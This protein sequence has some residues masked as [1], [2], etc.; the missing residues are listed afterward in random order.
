MAETLAGN[1][2]E[3]EIVARYRASAP[4][5]VDGLARELGIIVLYEDLGPNVAGMITVDDTDGPDRYIIRVHE[6]DPKRRRRFTLAHEVGH[7][8]LHR[9]LMDG[10]I[11]DNTMY[12]S[13]LGEWYER[14]ANRFAA[15]LLLP[16]HLVRAEF[17]GGTRSIAGLAET[18]DVSETAIRIRLDELGLGA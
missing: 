4:T 12:R 1:P 13:A 15:D 3:M 9:D 11:V 14:Q 6:N 8:L 10:N 16:A 18:F 7:F 5:D 17:N 2:D